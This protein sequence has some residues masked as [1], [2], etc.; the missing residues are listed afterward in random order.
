MDS[1]YLYLILNLLAISI[2]FFN[3]F[4]KR[5]NF[6]KK[7]KYFFPA[8]FLTGFFFI[9]WDV[10][11]TDW[12]VWGFNPRYLTGVTIINLP[13]EEWLFFITIPYACVFTYEAIKYLFKDQPLEK[14]S[15][16]ITWVLAIGLLTIAFFN[17]DKL[18]TATTF[19]LTGVFLL[20][21]LLIWKS[22]FMG[23]FYIAFAF[24]IIPFFV[25]NGILTGSWI[26]DQ[27]V[28]YNNS[29]NLGIRMFTIPVEDAFYGLLLILMNVSFY[30][31]FQKKY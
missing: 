5:A 20:M 24:I 22:K 12:G 14:G 30:E 25:I 1:P 21:H 31:G 27:V 16:W 7:W 26:E 4:D 2:P 9:S 15:I 23:H 19:I 17:L 6:S 13:L 10:Y 29:E 11:F 18:Y 3:S 8:C 28:W